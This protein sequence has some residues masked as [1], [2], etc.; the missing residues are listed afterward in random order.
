MSIN[1]CHFIIFH[2][3]GSILDEII[4]FIFHQEATDD[5]C[6]SKKKGKAIPVTG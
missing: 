6:K 1:I 2:V 5:D 4:E 3:E